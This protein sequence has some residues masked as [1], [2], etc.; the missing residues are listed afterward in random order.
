M[1]SVSYAV[2][3]LLCL[4]GSAHAEFLDRVDL[5]PAVVSGF[6]SHHIDTKLK[7]NESNAG[8]G[9]RFGRADILVGYYKNSEYRDSF[10][11]AYEA[12]WQLVKHLHL[13]VLAGAVS[14][15]KQ[16]SVQPLLLP[17]LVVTYRG[18]E[19]AA[20]YAPPAARNGV[21]V[22]AAQARWAW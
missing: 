3:G 11:V 8:V 18:W 21:A 9:Y 1:N 5:K 15:Y 13:G 20:V 10:Y 19:V 2:F 4:C 12:Q 14:G 6:V 17:E 7:F 16:A 22:V